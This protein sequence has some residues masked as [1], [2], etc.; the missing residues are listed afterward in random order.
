MASEILK[1]VEWQFKEL[2][3]EINALLTAPVEEIIPNK[4]HLAAQ[5]ELLKESLTEL[6]EYYFVQNID[7]IPNKMTILST[8]TNFQFKI[9]KFIS[10]LSEEI[11]TKEELNRLREELG[12]KWRNIQETFANL[13]QP[14]QSVIDMKELC[15]KYSTEDWS[16]FSLQR[17]QKMLW[18][19]S[20]RFSNVTIRQK[21]KNKMLECI[22]ELSPILK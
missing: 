20:S 12:L 9:S 8:L 18:F 4:V 11:P 19:Y 2:I 13:E 1:C 6:Y 5:V 17:V 14:F 10:F 21:P 22:F 15:Q 7:S 16:T 3:T